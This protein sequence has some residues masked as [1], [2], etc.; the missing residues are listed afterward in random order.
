MLQVQFLVP[1]PVTHPCD[2]PRRAK[3]AGG[4][5]TACLAEVR[6]LPSGPLAELFAVLSWRCF[7]LVSLMK[8]SGN[9]FECIKITGMQICEVVISNLIKIVKCGV[10]HL[11]KAT[12]L[13]T[14]VG[15]FDP[16]TP[17]HLF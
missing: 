14:V 9:S 10:G 8:Q 3:V 16:L 6:I 15:E 11:V 12:V 4:F 5:H 17:Y 2:F 1:Q 7:L 13:Q